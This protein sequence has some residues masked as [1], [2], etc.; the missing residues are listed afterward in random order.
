M[1]V[2]EDHGNMTERYAAFDQGHAPQD[3]RKAVRRRLY[4][5]ALRT[6]RSLNGYRFY[7]QNCG[8]RNNCCS[9]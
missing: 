2:K 6:V 9:A 4:S 5:F 3:E 1:Y 8:D 7:F